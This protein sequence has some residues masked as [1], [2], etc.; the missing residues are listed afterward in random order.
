MNNS[1]TRASLEI[2]AII[3]NT[4]TIEGLLGKGGMGSVFLCSHARLPGKQVAIKVLHT[5]VSN[6]EVL[7][8]FRREAEIASK[9]GH[10]NIVTVLDFN[11]LDDGTPYLVL[12]Y[13][14]G[15]SLWDRMR[16]GVLP[17]EFAL[18]LARQVGAALASAHREGIVHRD[19]KP[20]NLFL[21]ATETQG[22]PSEIVKV[23]DFGIAKTTEA[24]QARERKLTSPGMAMGT[25]EYMAPEQAA[26][27]P[28]DARCD[29][30]AL[31]AIV[32]E[33]LTGVAPYQGDNFM[34]ILTKKATIDPVSPSTLRPNLPD[35]VSTVVMSAMARNPDLRP[36]T[37]EAFEYELNKCLAGRGVA[38]A[39][40]LG[41]SS[42]ANLVANLN[43]G[44]SGGIA[45]PSAQT[46]PRPLS[47][48]GLPSAGV[49]V[50]TPALAASAPV[51]DSLA[52]M[53]GAPLWPESRSAHD[54]DS[55]A[56]FPNV[57][58]GAVRKS[59]VASEY[60]SA[61]TDFDE[62]LVLTRKSGIG[63]V[64]LAML[65]VCGAGALAFVAVGEWKASRKPV[66]TALV[67]AQVTTQILAPVGSAAEPV[68]VPPLPVGSG[69]GSAAPVPQNL[70]SNAGRTSP[71]EPAASEKPDKVGLDKN[72]KLRPKPPV[73]GKKMSGK[74]LVA[75]IERLSG[76][77]KMDDAEKVFEEL[78]KVRGYKGI[79]SYT[80]AYGLFQN[81]NYAGAARYAKT[82]ATDG[83]DKPK[84]M[85]LE[86]DAY[87][88]L[89]EFVKAKS[90]YLVV[91]RTA[92][93]ATK[94]T[95]RNKVNKCN[96]GLK[97]NKDHGL[98]SPA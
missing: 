24:E 26:G 49:A 50:A 36:Q 43:P 33:M 80:Y 78:R 17:L 34:E 95:L 61:P 25:P 74:Q 39:Q 13:L 9:L 91:W 11:A 75:E 7:S 21:V 23:L 55:R 31:G 97:L 67:P 85:E 73:E 58:S 52:D 71:N 92:D 3:A 87:L 42:D 30:Y 44:L 48:A 64:L 37:M 2:G 77:A 65:L 66:N 53:V 51:R 83:F 4:Y 38:V 79:A 27:R 62:S 68:T 72:D 40:I 29:V 89:N 81:K 84:S 63:S 47:N 82:A 8:R 56:L 90:L 16:Q 28:A 10:P 54:S 76:A 86:G 59:A 5:E 12:E 93:T 98:D 96:A 1:L 94:T 69:S 14:V 19:L 32:F 6:S 15:E 45:P 88:R 46:Y 20:H 60:S 41:M 18:S 35:A 22:R 70:G 57:P